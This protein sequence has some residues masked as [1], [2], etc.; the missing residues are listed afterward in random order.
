PTGKS[1]FGNWS[2][3]SR[4]YENRP[5]TTMASITIVAKTGFFRLTR[6]NHMAGS[7]LGR[8]ARRQAR[9]LH[10]RA[11]AQRPERALDDHGA[12]RHAFHGDHGL[13][14]GIAARA[15]F[16]GLVGDLAAFD[17]LHVRRG[18]VGAH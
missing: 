18:L 7:G 16:H 5:S 8:A 15:G 1:M 14:L 12:G 10:L 6:V 13:A 4:W 2:T 17:H 9:E 3:F 11:F